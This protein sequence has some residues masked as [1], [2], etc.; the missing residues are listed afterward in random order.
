M[1]SLWATASAAWSALCRW[2]SSLSRNAMS[3]R[4]NY[5]EQRIVSLSI[6]SIA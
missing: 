5:Q 2:P 6:S 1:S 3:A 4:L